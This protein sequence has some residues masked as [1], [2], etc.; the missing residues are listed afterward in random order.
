[1]LTFDPRF[2]IATLLRSYHTMLP[3]PGQNLEPSPSSGF[4]L[5]DNTHLHEKRP[6]MAL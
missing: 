1:M 5:N 4:T 2:I 6:E 3:L